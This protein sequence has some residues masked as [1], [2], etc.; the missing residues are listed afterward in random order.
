MATGCVVIVGTAVI[1]IATTASGSTVTMVVILILTV[2]VVVTVTVVVM[3]LSTGV[4]ISQAFESRRSA[5]A[6]LTHGPRDEG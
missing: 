2:A 5:L 3:Y 1:H 4:V 6:V